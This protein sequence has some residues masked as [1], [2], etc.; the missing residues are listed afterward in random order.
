MSASEVKDTLERIVKEM[1]RLAVLID[2]HGTQGAAAAVDMRINWDKFQKLFM[3]LGRVKRIGYYLTVVEPINEYDYTTLDSSTKP[4]WRGVIDWMGYNNFKVTVKQGREV[5][6][7]DSGT[8]GVKTSIDLSLAVDAMVL[9]DDVEHII[10]FSGNADFVPLVQALQS[11]NVSVTVVSNS[12]N[13]VL[14]ADRKE[15]VSPFIASK[16]LIRT[17]NNFIELGALYPLIGQPKS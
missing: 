13:G 15:G 3:E 8:I 4:W 9:A 12:Y 5:T 14:K 11:K 10:L 1:D 2:G 7:T 17:A 16:N 6:F